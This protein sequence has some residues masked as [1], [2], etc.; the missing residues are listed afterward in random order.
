[1]AVLEEKSSI[2]K[3]LYELVDLVH[4]IEET[5]KGE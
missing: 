1:M 2:W 5:Q 4:E 3:A